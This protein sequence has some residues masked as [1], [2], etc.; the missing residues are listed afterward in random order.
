MTGNSYFT[1][2][3]TLSN[4]FPT[5]CC[6]HRDPARDTRR[7]WGRQSRS[8]IPR[9]A[10][11][12]SCAGNS[13]FSINCQT[14][15]AGSGVCRK[16]RKPFA[17]RHPVGRHPGSIFEQFAGARH[18]RHQSAFGHHRKSVQGVAAE[19]DGVER[20]DRGVEPA[21]D[22]VS[23]IYRPG[24]ALAGAPANGVLLQGNPAGSSY[25]ESLNARLQ[26]RLSNSLTLLNNFSWSRLTDRLAYL[27]DSDPAP[28]K[29]ISA[30]RVR[31][32]T[33]WRQLTRCR[34]GEAA[35]SISRTRGSTAW[36]VVGD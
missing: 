10:T 13:V 28:E 12:T 36:R 16:S 3:A 32:A 17:D 35:P 14:V 34:S 25:Y 8:L 29:R 21:A 23:A 7:I 27:N 9:C 2:S 30:T 20:F 31:C 15:R 22:P 26:K 11:P 5:G 1:P 4:P 33:F 18:Q 24:S 19:L 6:N